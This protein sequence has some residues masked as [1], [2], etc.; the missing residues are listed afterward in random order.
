MEKKIKNREAKRLFS[1]PNRMK[2]GSKQVQAEL[3][4]L[5]PGWCWEWG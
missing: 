4:W 3:G 1:F 5:G 2:E